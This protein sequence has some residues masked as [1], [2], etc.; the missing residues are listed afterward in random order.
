VKE[1]VQVAPNAK[2]DSQKVG[3]LASMKILFDGQKFLRDPQEWNESEFARQLH[4]QILARTLPKVYNAGL[5]DIEAVMEDLTQ[6]DVLQSLRNGV[7]RVRRVPL[8]AYSSVPAG[9]VGR[10]FLQR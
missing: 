2:E 7:L 1:G 8:K 9:S 6:G 5:V 3:V 4:C 10:V